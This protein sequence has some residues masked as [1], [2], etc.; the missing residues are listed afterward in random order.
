[1]QC[2]SE[3]WEFPP[4]PGSNDNCGPPGCAGIDT[5][6]LV[7]TGALPLAYVFGRYWNIGGAQ[8]PG[9]ASSLPSDANAVGGVLEPGGSVSFA[10]SYLGQITGLVGSAEPFS[11]PDGGVAIA[12]EGTIFWPEGVAGSGGSMVMHVAEIEVYPSCQSV[13]QAW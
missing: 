7:N 10:S 6:L 9:V 13:A 11:S 1:M 3:L 8:E 5:V 12:D 4:F 2:P